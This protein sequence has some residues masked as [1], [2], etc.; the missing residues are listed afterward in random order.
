MT[1]PRLER[2]H[3]A[4]HGGGP[5]TDRP[6]GTTGLGGLTRA[7][8]RRLESMAESDALVDAIAGFSLF[9]DLTDPQLERVVH[10]F[11]EAVYAAGR[12]GPPPGH[13]RIRV[14]RD[15]RGRGGRHRRRDRA[16]PTGPR[17][18]L[19]RG[20]RSSS[21][22]RRS[23]TSSRPRTLRCLRAVRVRPSRAFLIEHPRVMYRMLQVQAR[24][25]RAANRWRS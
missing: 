10:T 25:L 24:R 15:P 13:E 8:P 1:R 3:A 23:P 5:S 17:R 16:G 7:S 19:R 12:A 4:P 11:E 20:R 18:I 22:S 2:R 6:T 21:A 14:P 9:A